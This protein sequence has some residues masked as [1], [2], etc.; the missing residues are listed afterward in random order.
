LSLFQENSFNEDDS[1]RWGS[2]VA[3]LESVH[4]ESSAEKISIECTIKSTVDTKKFKL[5]YQITDNVNN[6]VLGGSTLNSLDEARWFKL[7]SNES[8]KVTF[9]MP[10]ILGNGIYYVGLQI[11]SE[12]EEVYEQW[13]RID[14]ITNIRQNAPYPIV[15]PA[16]MEIK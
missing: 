8:K 4:V 5:G 2:G 10:N 3:K 16:R 13:R 6:V 1:Q 11:V 12:D 14:R 7:K 9:S 15:S